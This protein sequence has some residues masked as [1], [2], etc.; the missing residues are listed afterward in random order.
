MIVNAGDPEAAA[1]ANGRSAVAKFF[2]TAPFMTVGSRPSAWSIQPIMPVT[3]DLP[4][5][6]ATPIRTRLSLNS[7]ASRSARRI[8]CAPT[9]VAAAM[10]GTVS[11]TAADA[12][13]ICSDEAMPLPSWG[14]RSIPSARSAANFGASRP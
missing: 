7:D 2:I 11:S 14:K 10:S 1:L 5:V 13:T 3:V 9:R 8:R 12:T 4:L 6:P